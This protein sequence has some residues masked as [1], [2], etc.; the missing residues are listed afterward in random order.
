M[1]L[2]RFLS[3]EGQDEPNAAEDCTTFEGV[4]EHERN[5]DDLQRGR[6]ELRHGTQKIKP[7]KQ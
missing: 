1:F 4:S 5:A 2:Q 3:F 7:G 6:H